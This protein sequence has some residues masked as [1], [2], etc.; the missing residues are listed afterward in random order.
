MRLIRS[1]C[2]SA[3]VGFSLRFQWRQ[4]TTISSA[5]L[6]SGHGSRILRCDRLYASA[7]SAT[8]VLED[9]KSRKRPSKNDRRAMVETFVNEYR[10]TNDG[11]FP[12]L[13]HTIKEVGGG[14]YYVRQIVQE[15]LYNSK[16]SSD[17]KYVSMGKSATK[18]NEMAYN[19]RNAID[20]KD[21]NL[22]KSMTENN[23][24]LC[25]SKERPMDTKD[26]SLEKS[27][28][29]ED[30]IFTKFEEVPQAKEELGEDTRPILEYVENS[31]SMTFQ[32]KQDQ[33][34]SVEI[35]EPKDVGAQFHHL[36]DK[37]ESSRNPD[38]VKE[39]EI[40]QDKV[41][42]DALEHKA[43]PVESAEIS[44]RRLQEEPHNYAESQR[45]SS[46]WNNLKSFANGILSIWKRS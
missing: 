32:S 8:S 44:G 3:N 13:S 20:F 10:I 7:S 29:K 14:Y 2:R 4:D 5:S 37:P 25:N 42:S 26:T 41:L 21:I 46:V 18:K 1:V 38:Y 11:K 22:E 9:R 6:H 19:S 27:A 33:F 24:I 40:L 43:W 17:S 31:S 36:I 28:T 35:D 12:T 34:V 39:H 23:E 45:K 15:M 16:Q 30:K